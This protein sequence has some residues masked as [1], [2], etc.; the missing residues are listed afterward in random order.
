M[1]EQLI[2]VPYFSLLWR[3]VDRGLG[4]RADCV[5]RQ[6]LVNVL[7]L[8]DITEFLQILCT[9][10][11]RMSVAFFVGRLFAVTRMV[12]IWLYGYTL[13]MSVSM[14]VTAIVTFCVCYPDKALWHIQPGSIT[15]CSSTTGLNF[16]NYYNG[17][18][19]ALSDLLL[20]I[21]PSYFLFRLHLSMKQKVGLSLLMAVG[22]IPAGCCLARTILMRD[23]D[24]S[25]P[26]SKYRSIQ[27]YISAY[28]SPDSF[29]KVVL[30]GGIEAS[31]LVIC[32]CIPAMRPLFL[33]RHRGRGVLK[34][35]G[36]KVHPSPKVTPYSSGVNTPNRNQIHV[37]QDLR[38]ESYPRI[39]GQTLV[40]DCPRMG[41]ERAG[42]T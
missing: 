24:N 15:S 42:H 36:W 4:Y 2:L 20:A 5:S 12:R 40:E 25:Q 26:L 16:R 8:E 1:Y 30:F 35:L 39:S 34:T 32:A 7:E 33:S 6:D 10:F 13:L 23:L 37:T 3:M 41:E 19:G 31:A 9:M 22:L 14:V 17:S 38:V 27:S 11:S 29:A 18:V 21:T 28:S